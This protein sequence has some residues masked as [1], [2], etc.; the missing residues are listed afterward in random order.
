M[1]AVSPSNSTPLRWLHG[2]ASDL[3][4]GCGLGYILTIPLLLLLTDG[5]QLGGWPTLLGISLSLLVSGPH[6]GATIRRVYNESTDR[7]RYKF[8]AL[9]LTVFLAFM[10][11]LH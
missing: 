1:A 4:L 5:T 8:F 2:P 3:L 10:F 6:Y 11:V 9:H 7:R